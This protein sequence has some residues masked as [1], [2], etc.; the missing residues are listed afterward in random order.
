MGA[1]ADVVMA[2]TPCGQRISIVRLPSST[3]RPDGLKGI[4]AE[5]MSHLEH[6]RPSPRGF[7]EAEGDQVLVPVDIDAL[8]KAGNDIASSVL[9][10]CEL[11]DGEIVRAELFAD[12]ADTI[13]ALR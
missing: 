1:D 12:T 5:P 7:F 3:T 13:E 10:L 2:G 11:R 8:T 6:F 9:W 4:G